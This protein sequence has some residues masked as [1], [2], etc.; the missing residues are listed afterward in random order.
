MTGFPP[1]DR[2]D[3]AGV[4]AGDCTSRIAGRARVVRGTM[5]A[6]PARA[7]EG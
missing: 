1:I 6:K 4:R 3:A 7:A 2:I 5:Q